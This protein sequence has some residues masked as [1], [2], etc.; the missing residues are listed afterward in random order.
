MDIARI[1]NWTRYGNLMIEVGQYE[2]SLDIFLRLENYCIY[3][4]NSKKHMIVDKVKKFWYFA[5]F[6]FN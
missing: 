4:L 5:V 6:N 2:K 3:Y 1:I